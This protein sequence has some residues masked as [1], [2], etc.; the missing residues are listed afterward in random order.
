M[1]ATTPS[2]TAHLGQPSGVESIEERF[3]DAVL[4][5][6]NLVGTYVRTTVQDNNALGL[7]DG[8]ELADE[9]DGFDAETERT[10]VD[11]FMEWFR[12]VVEDELLEPVPTVEVQAGNHWT[13]RFIRA[14]YITGWEQATG[15]LW[16]EGVGAESFDDEEVFQLD[17]PREQLE[18]LYTRTYQ[19]LSDISEAMAQTIREELTNGLKA[20]E[21]PRKM[22]SRLTDEIDDITNTR[23][24]TLARTEVAI[25]HSKSTLDRYERA[26]VDVVSHGEWLTADDNRVCP[27]CSALDGKEFRIPEMRTG[28]FY[29][30]APGDVPDYLAGEYPLMPGKTHPNCRCSVLPVVS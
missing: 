14:G 26:G 17:V 6:A 9:R 27:I 21:N 10:L 13:G 30:D 7:A 20:G 23:L 16:N 18:E 12:T 19:N 28:T 15:R 25:S 29:F 22:A 5:R 4:E 8:V 1:S 24:K 3:L 2:T 11:R